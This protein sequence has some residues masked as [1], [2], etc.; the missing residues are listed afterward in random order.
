MRK[1]AIDAADIRILCAVQHHGHLSKA[2]LSEIV[3][4]SP[5]P[6]WIRFNRLRAAG[7]I[8]GYHA[9]I[10]VDKLA[11]V[12]RVIVTVSL[13]GHRT[14]DFQRFEQHIQRIDEIVECMATGGGMDYV[15][16]V[17]TVSLPAFQGVMEELLSADLG[18]DRYVTYITTREIK[19]SQPNL[20]T[21]VRNARS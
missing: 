15:L 16:K 7:L 13:K 20:T 17:L 18:I 14:A 11:D 8:R 4:L 6:C 12:I 19:S 3:N 1:I 2:R 10:A 21:L 5:T 9:D